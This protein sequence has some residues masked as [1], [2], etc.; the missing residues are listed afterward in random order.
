VGDALRQRRGAEVDGL[1]TT[2]NYLQ[3]TTSG[4]AGSGLGATAKYL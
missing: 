4:A 2:A 3:S 1:G